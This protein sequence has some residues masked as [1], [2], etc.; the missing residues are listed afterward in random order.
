M[1]LL[2]VIRLDVVTKN[3]TNHWYLLQIAPLYHKNAMRQSKKGVEGRLPCSLP[4][5]EYS[6]MRRKNGFVVGLFFIFE[7]ASVHL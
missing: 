7:K 2:L 3:I 5:S 4:I 1:M 6:V